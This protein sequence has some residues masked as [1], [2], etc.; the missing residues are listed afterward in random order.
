MKI[1]ENFFEFNGW[2]LGNANLGGPIQLAYKKGNN[3]KKKK[4]YHSMAHEYFLVLNG[5]AAIKIEDKEVKLKKGSVVVVEPGE[6]H[7]LYDRSSNFEI[8]ILMD[9][10][11]ENDTNI[12]EP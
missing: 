7:W 1:I 9:K 4:H 6:K 12:T 3:D 5:T 8:L 2:F 10:F 11:F